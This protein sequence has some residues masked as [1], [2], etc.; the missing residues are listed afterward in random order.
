MKAMVQNIG[1]WAGFSAFALV[2]LAAFQTMGLLDIDIFALSGKTILAVEGRMSVSSFTVT[3]PP[4]PLIWT[5][6]FAYLAPTGALPA[7]LAAAV[8]VGILGA[9]IYRGF[10]SRQYSLLTSLIATLLI[11][12]NPLALNALATGPDAALMMLTVFAFA[13]A[14][15]AFAFKSSIPDLMLAAAA[16]M[17]L[18]FI[19]P[20]G[21]LFAAAALP[22]LALIAPP[23]LLAR[24]P[25]PMFLVFLFPVAFA[26]AS[27]AYTSWVFGG[28]PL[29]FLQ[30]ATAL[31]VADGITK[32][33]LARASAEILPAAVLAAPLLPAFFIWSR[34]RSFLRNPAIALT[35]LVLT[36][37]ILH[38]AMGGR[39]D[40]TAILAAAL[41]IVAVCAINT[42]IHGLRGVHVCI[43]LAFGIFG[44]T[45]I[46]APSDTR[47]MRAHARAATA[48][49]PDAILAL[50][51]I[52]RTKNGVLI[53][54]GAHPGFVAARATTAGLVVPGD[55]EFETQLQSQRL[56]SPFVVVAPSE[57]AIVP[58]RVAVTF[59][60]LYH[61]GAPGYH[62]IHS[63]GRWRLYAR[64]TSIGGV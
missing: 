61:F 54:A 44:A 33:S 35:L 60:Q 47:E 59:P 50:S 63:F 52:L 6:P 1:L 9:A 39:G 10:Y 62:L 42:P 46:V 53:D 55:A 5:L 28:A 12:G 37:G 20:Y 14:L 29:A 7:V 36:A 27:F 11:I 24:T 38:L 43:L 48:A 4:L 26:L 2:M 32:L 51:E 15:F 64:L 56:T 8:A 57:T 21:L 22:G 18:A 58:D 25:L 30:T 3:Y 17:I 16:L 31:I 23:V 19:H 49:D 41:P 40:K 34:R 45:I 13:S